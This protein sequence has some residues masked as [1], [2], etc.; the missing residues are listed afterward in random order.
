M[1]CPK[2]GS[3]ALHLTADEGNIL[4]YCSM[5]QCPFWFRVERHQAIDALF[6]IYT[7]GEA[8]T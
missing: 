6:T 2:C 5:A 1:K 3:A 8:I 7:R 4:V